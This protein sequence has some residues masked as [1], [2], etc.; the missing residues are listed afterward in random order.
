MAESG[1]IERRLV[2]SAGAMLVLSGLL[3]G[4]IGPFTANPRM[5]L[6]AHLEGLMNGILLIALGAAWPHLQLTRQWRRVT[7]GLLLYGTF[8]NWLTVLAAA[9][10]NAGR[11]TPIAG[12]APTASDWQEAVVGFGLI[13]LSAAM[14]GAFGLLTW[15]FWRGR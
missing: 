5:G 13:S 7:L 2:L 9:F 12:P 1:N 3:T 10:W 14:I 15:G 6:S 11:F 4:L 8:V